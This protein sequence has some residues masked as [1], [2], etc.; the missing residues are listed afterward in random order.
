MNSTLPYV[1]QDSN[2]PYNTQIFTSSPSNL[3]MTWLQY[4]YNSKQEKTML[5]QWFS[6]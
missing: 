2:F 4:E 6:C 5:Q 1:Q 3:T